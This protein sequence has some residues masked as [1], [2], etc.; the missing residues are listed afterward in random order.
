[1]PTN[2]FPTQQAVGELQSAINAQSRASIG[3]A[4]RPQPQTPVS[5]S[6]TAAKT[7]L[8]QLE[9]Q[10]QSLFERLIPILDNGPCKDQGEDASPPSM[11]PLIVDI[12][13]IRQRLA[14][15]NFVVGEISQRLCI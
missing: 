7:E 2:P 13:N 3:V 15:A 5:E 10:L 1:M 4:D 12:T 9:Q 14:K 6:I 8:A 11:C